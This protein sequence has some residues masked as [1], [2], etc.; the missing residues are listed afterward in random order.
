MKKAIVIY[1]TQFGN[2][3]QIANALTQ[4]M[5]KQGIFVDFLKL[6]KLISIT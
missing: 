6:M 3:R 1:A 2:A 5:E 4:G